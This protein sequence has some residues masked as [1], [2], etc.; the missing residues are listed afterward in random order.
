MV[1]SRIRLVMLRKHLLS[2]VNSEER[3]FV[4][5]FAFIAFLVIYEPVLM[6]YYVI[7]M[8]CLHLLILIGSF[9]L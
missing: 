2:T 6:K 8:L 3:E 7:E 1:A 9:N 4:L 5:V